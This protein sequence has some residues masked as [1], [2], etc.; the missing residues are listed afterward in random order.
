MLIFSICLLRFYYN[1]KLNNRH[2]ISYQQQDFTDMILLK[3]EFNLA[4]GFCYKTGDFIMKYK[5]HI[6]IDMK[7]LKH[8]Q[9]VLPDGTY[10]M[11]LAANKTDAVNIFSLSTG[12]T[13][14]NL[15]ANY[16]SWFDMQDQKTWR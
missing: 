16:I 13:N 5:K 4:R 11:T 3:Y 7:N 14:K 10:N 2:K 12:R 15:L 6:F 1:T 9:L 8:Y